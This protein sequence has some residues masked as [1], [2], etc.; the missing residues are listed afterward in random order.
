MEQSQ[1]QK[2]IYDIIKVMI[3]KIIRDFNNCA[4]ADSAI[5]FM[6]ELQ[7]QNPSIKYKDRNG[8]YVWGNYYILPS[9]TSKNSEF[10]SNLDKNFKIVNPIC[11]TS[12]PELVD[13]AETKDKKFTAIFYKIN[14]TLN[15]DLI[16]YMQTKG[17]TGDKIELFKSEQIELLEKTGLY[18]NKFFNSLNRF[19]LTPDTN[20]ILFEDWSELKKYENKTEKNSFIQN[21]DSLL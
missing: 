13:I 19:Y 6:V 21:L 17:A 5:K 1:A 16:P 14:E 10:L 11:K 3:T 15:A 20:I 9:Y 2:I 7:K 18:N 4:N 8:A 12:S